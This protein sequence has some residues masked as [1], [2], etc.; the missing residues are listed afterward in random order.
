VVIKPWAAADWL[1][2][3]S[4]TAAASRSKTTAQDR[5]GGKGGTPF[6]TP[7]LNYTPLLAENKEKSNKRG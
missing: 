1:A 5:K 4:G 2:N 6:K 3:A 7:E